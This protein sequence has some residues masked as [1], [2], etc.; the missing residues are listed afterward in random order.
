MAVNLNT[1]IPQ[2][3][4]QM[5]PVDET[6]KAEVAAQ[7]ASVLE[8]IGV[9]VSQTKGV[10]DDAAKAGILSEPVLDE[11]DEALAAKA[12]LEALVAYLQMEMNEQQSKVQA[13]RIESLKG[14]LTSAHSV[15]MDKINESIEKAL[16]Q[17]RTAKAQRVLSWIG[18]IFSVVVAAVVTVT[19]GGLAAGFAIAGAALAVSSLAMSEFGADKAIMKKLAESIKEDFGCDKQTAEAWAQ[20]IYGGIELI[21][22][23]TCA[24]G[25]GVSAAKAIGKSAD[26]AVKIGTKAATFVKYGQSIG[27]SAMKVTSMTTTAFA[28]GYGYAA[29]RAQA[30]ATE[31]QAIL[32]KLQRFL[33]E[34]EEELQEILQQL[35]NMG[36][37]VMALLESKTDTLNKIAQEIGSQTA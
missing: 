34:S 36:S 15:Q 33:E 32:D 8:S 4:S 37:Q 17:E 25:G 22:G 6:K 10:A 9:E 19:T 21:L 29:G 3:A 18:M 1:N 7:L 23:L 13:Q 14:Q 27:G 28:M 35:M 31:V 12:D 24:I 11:A 2:V 16:E 5:T 30:D 20:G 26:L